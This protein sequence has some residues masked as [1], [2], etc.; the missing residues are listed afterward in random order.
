VLILVPATAALDALFAAAAPALSGEAVKTPATAAFKNVLDDLALLAEPQPGGGAEQQSAAVPEPASKKQQA[1]TPASITDIA[2]VPQATA[3]K[4][5]QARLALPRAALQTA[6]DG[7]VTPSA[8]S[9]R[10]LSNDSTPAAPPRDHDIAVAAS[11]LP[12]RTALPAN[13]GGSPA[14]IAKRFTSPSVLVRIPFGTAATQAPIREVS[15]PEVPA[16]AASTPPVASAPS[17]PESIE[18]PSA[19]VAAEITQAPSEAA[20]SNPTVRFTL[21]AQQPVTGQPSAPLPIQQNTSGPKVTTPSAKNSSEQPARANTTPAASTVRAAIPAGATSTV[22]VPANDKAPAAD[23]SPMGTSTVISIAPSQQAVDKTADKTKTSD[24]APQTRPAPQLPARPSGFT[25]PPAAPEFLTAPVPMAPVLEQARPEPAPQEQ[26]STSADTSS[27]APP[28]LEPAG[29]AQSPTVQTSPVPSMPARSLSATA[30]AQVA[31]S[32]PADD[33]IAQ[34]SGPSTSQ[35]QAASAVP[36]AKS[37]LLPQAEN[38]AF[39]MRLL[40]LDDDSNRVPLTPAATSSSNTV[41]SLTQS[42]TQPAIQPVTQPVTQP[43]QPALQPQNSPAQPAT[44]TQGQG[45]SAQNTSQQNPNQATHETQ[46][47]APTTS[48]PEPAAQGQPEI[49][50]APKAAQASHPGDATVLQVPQQVPGQSFQVES[51]AAGHERGTTAEPH[52]LL[53]AQDTRLAGTE[54]PRSS[55]SSEILLHLTGDDQAPAAIRVADRAGSVN[56]S[57]HAADPV[58]RESLKTNLGDLSAQLNLQ[59]WKTETT[60]SAA[61]AAHSD[62]PQDSHTGGQRGSGQQASGGDRPP[63]RERRGNGGQWRQAFDQQITGNETLPGGNR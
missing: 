53:A 34:P 59:G 50:T 1:Q 35:S 4:L 17:T 28:H 42:I 45:T 36:Q 13:S 14:P 27:A 7:D 33:R 5:P 46:P 32:Q 8:A 60:K 61:V 23:V 10:S 58:L 29:D 43:Q 31:I 20:I 55:A 56:V 63:Q 19:P 52:M 2:V 24:S 62:N 37:P 15:Q 40:G 9:S 51:P 18:T 26:T 25:T 6:T 57:V 12:V 39:S 11:T 3:I 47:A 16:R 49:S 22:P 54:L 38:F 21:P 41:P 44:T 48:Q 30:P